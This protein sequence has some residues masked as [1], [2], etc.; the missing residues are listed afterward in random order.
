ML[1]KKGEDT[2]LLLDEG[3]KHGFLVK[4]TNVTEL[5]ISEFVVAYGFDINVGSWQ[6]GGYYS[7][8]KEAVKIYLEMEAET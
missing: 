8:F 5:I 4:V 6:G 2:Y 3:E 7:D 1:I